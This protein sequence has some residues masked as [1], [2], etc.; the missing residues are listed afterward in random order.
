MDSDAASSADWSTRPMGHDT[1]GHGHPLPPLVQCCIATNWQD[2]QV[3]SIFVHDGVMVKLMQITHSKPGKTGCPKSHCVLV[4]LATGEK[5]ER[6]FRHAFGKARRTGCQPTDDTCDVL[7]VQRTEY[8]LT[9][10][11]ADGFLGLLSDEGTMREDLQSHNHD[12]LER[13]RAALQREAAGT[14]VVVGQS[15]LGLEAVESFVE[16]LDTQ[17]P[18]G[19]EYVS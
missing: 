10:I 15:Q 12:L 3:G 17:S 11:D 1:A 19:R 5:K 2:V 13:M 9:S 4:D 14:V 8:T 16:H 18:A 7:H 6:L